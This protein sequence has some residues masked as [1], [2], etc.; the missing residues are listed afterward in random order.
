MKKYIIAFLLLAVLKGIFQANGSPYAPIAIL[1]LI[2][3]ILALYFKQVSSFLSISFKVVKYFIKS[4]QVKKSDVSDYSWLV[5]YKTLQ[6]FLDSGDYTGFEKFYSSYS[7]TEEQDTALTLLTNS[8][9]NF[10]TIKKWD[11]EQNT[12]LTNILLAKIYI[13]L[14]WDSR[15]G[16]YAKDV[17]Q[18]QWVGFHDYLKLAKSCLEQSIS[19]HCPTQNISSYTGLITVGLDYSEGEN[20]YERFETQEQLQEYFA[21][22]K[23]EV[24]GYFELGRSIDSNNLNLYRGMGNY[25][26]EK[27]HGEKGELYDFAQKYGNTKDKFFSLQLLCLV[28]DWLQMIGDDDEEIKK[29]QKLELT[30]K[31]KD[32]NAQFGSFGETLKAAK[33]KDY[34]IIL[35]YLTFLYWT[36]IGDR[37]QF[38][39]Y[40][41]A[42]NERLTAHPWIYNSV[43]TPKDLYML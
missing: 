38:E 20:I 13:T 10:D 9:K 32:L 7:T 1:V 28:E 24:H 11:A 3:V 5:D 17:S 14:A 35:N 6:G 36:E 8:S 29:S 12:Q 33:P 42:L 26:A 15:S 25:L 2:L 43:E 30:Q 39:I 40:R 41:D 27:W 4:S 34:Y 19:D 37:K 31:L 21:Q 22:K 18:E 23:Q 16:K